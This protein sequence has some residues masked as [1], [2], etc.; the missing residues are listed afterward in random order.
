MNFFL[1]IIIYIALI[2]LDSST[3]DSFSVWHEEGWMAN[4]IC[5]MTTDE[6]LEYGKVEGWRNLEND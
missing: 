2:R 6:M 5:I 3:A 1:K 4:P